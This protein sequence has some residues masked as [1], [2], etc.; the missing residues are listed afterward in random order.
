[1]RSLIKIYL[2]IVFIAL[3][4][5]LPAQA[6]TPYSKNNLMAELKVQYG[7]L[8]SHHLELDVFQ[9]HFPAFEFSIE[10]ATWGKS[11][12]EVIYGYPIVG[13]SVWY[14]PLGGFDELGYAIAVYPFINFPIVKDEIQS[15]NFRLGAGL[16]YLSNYY[17]NKSNY[18]NFA[19]GS[20]INVAG[21]LYFEY[22]RK[23][24]NMITLS[25]GIGLTHFSNGSMKTPNYGLNLIT[26]TIG[27]TTYLK[28]PNPQ[29]SNKILPKLYPFEFD[30]KK[31]LDVDA[32]ISIGH[33]DMSQ[34]FGKKFMV[35]ALTANIFKQIS[36]KS[37]FGVG[38]D[39]TYDASDKFI[40]KWRGEPAENNW[41]VLKPG[42]NAAYQL[43]ISN[44]SFVFNFG[45]YLAGKE[46]A[47][48][49]VY[50]RLSMRY[51][52]ADFLFANI[53]VN[54]NW[55]KAEYIG[56]GIGY[57]LNF[58]YKRAIKH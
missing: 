58:I 40:L 34:Q 41:Q 23:V 50:Q 2:F 17:H 26:G 19:I 21:S 38:I 48:G 22:R 7:F 45:I 4:V 31:S 53:S 42:I 39:L 36:W 32:S 1:M 18:R 52:F 14:S 46:R 55:G 3:R 29:L 13:L 35:Y 56:F 33:K 37:K 16:G 49:D 27:I 24:S 44:L 57:Q 12:W 9:S 6:H 43:V 10:K 15:F 30:G 54:T 28:R 47:E 20:N 11:R 51:L 8:A 5:N 25:A